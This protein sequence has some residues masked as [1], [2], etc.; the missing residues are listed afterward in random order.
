M[1]ESTLQFATIVTPDADPVK[2]DAVLSVLKDFYA[3]KNANARSVSPRLL[4][5][6]LH[7]FRVTRHWELHVR[8]LMGPADTWAAQLRRD[9]SAQ[10]VFAVI[11][12]VGGKNWAPVQHFCEETKLPCIFPNVELPVV[13]EQIFT[14]SI[15][16]KVCCGKRG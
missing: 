8:E 11:S 4:S 5:N 9:L 12:G 7:N 2:R 14:R 10:P 15:F 3:E 6:R 13:E 1:S 16:P